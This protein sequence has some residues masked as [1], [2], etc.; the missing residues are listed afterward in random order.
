MIR[1][2]EFN[3]KYNRATPNDIVHVCCSYFGFSEEEIFT[4]SRKSEKVMVR[5]IIMYLMSRYAGMTL[6]G[7]ADYFKFHGSI[8]NHATVIHS[9]TN[10]E[11]LMDVDKEYRSH[12]V[13]IERAIGIDRRNYLTSRYFMNL[14][15]GDTIVLSHETDEGIKRTKWRHM[16]V[17]RKDGVL[18]AIGQTQLDSGAWRTHEDLIF[19]DKFNM[20]I[21][22]YADELFID[23]S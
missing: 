22:E 19:Q 4:K 12:I 15:R 5:Q 7:I 11:N 16:K 18:Y 3:I 23:E 17:E 9:R 14:R 6:T 8:G 21:G 1:T 10:V 2:N 20:C 13:S